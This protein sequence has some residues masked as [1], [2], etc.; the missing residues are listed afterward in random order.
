VTLAGRR[1]TSPAPE[2]FRAEAVRGPGMTYRG[3]A[4][5]AIVDSQVM[6]RHLRIAPRRRRWSASTTLDIEPA[7]AP[8]HTQ[9][10]SATSD[11]HPA[12]RRRGAGRR[13]L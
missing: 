13:A 5:E 12:P 6:P 7:S 11:A 1:L 9:R 4:F 2:R 8:R 3:P 10:D